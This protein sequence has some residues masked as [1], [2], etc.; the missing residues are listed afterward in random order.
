M[1]RHASKPG[2]KREAMRGRTHAAGAEAPLQLPH[3]RDQTA[4]PVQ[5]KS[6]VIRQ[7]EKDVVEGQV[8]T[9][10]YTRARGVANRRKAT[11]GR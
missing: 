10:N 11:G 5:R 8:D 1:K 9:D 4:E 6:G 7:A 3:E 2:G